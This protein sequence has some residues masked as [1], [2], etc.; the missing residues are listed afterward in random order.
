MIVPLTPLDFRLRAA[1]IFP[2]VTGVVDGERRFTYA[3]YDER[4]SRLAGF[5]KGLG[6]G[7][8]D[9]VS[10]LSFNSHQLLEGYYGVLQA[11]CVLN[12]I[13]V[14]LAP[15]DIAYVLGHSDTR[16]VIFHA[17]FL[18]MVERLRESIP[19]IRHF[20]SCELA[21]PPAWAVDYEA[22]LSGAAPDV[23]DLDSIDE[24]ATAELFYTSGTTGLPKG[25]ASTHRTLYLHGLSGMWALH[26]ADDDVA[27]HVVP[28]FHVNGWGTPHSVT[29]AGARHVMLRKFDPVELLR[30][31]QTERVTLVLGVPLIFGA[32]LNHPRL[33]EFDLSSLRTCIVGG[34]PASPTL[35]RAMEDRLTCQA[36]VGYGMTETSP[37]LTVA[38]P[39]AGLSGNRDQRLS[40]QAK[41]GVPMPGVRLRVVNAQG[42]DVARNGEEV[43]EIITRS[44]VVMTGYYKDE[45]ATAAAIRDGWFYT[46]DMAV[47]DAEGYVLIVDRKK[48]IIISGGENIAS[49]EVENAVYSH[50][51]VMECAVVPVP[52]AT[53]G[54]VPLAAVVL[55]PGEALTAEELLEYLRL[56]LAHYKLPRR[57]EFVEEL[58]KTGT[59]KVLKAKIKEPYWK[60][61]EKRV[62]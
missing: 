28:L 23:P 4:V 25:V 36:V 17:D 8:G 29:G 27:L 42:R 51:A 7:H 40:Y 19:T 14:R 32:V 38:W 33:G 41:T 22:A 55:K 50:P 18:P 48:D 21:S 53:W 39:K 3:D 5:L 54:E 20:V 46:G 45:R 30:L 49:V 43:G 62:N 61:S 9:V 52:D 10:Y 12:P 31:V 26:V 16:A 34:A 44:N 58:P 1:Q 2:A 6:L 57:V 37:V 60:G 11:G 59:G 15:Q 13:N 47:M 35:I 24:N 56:H